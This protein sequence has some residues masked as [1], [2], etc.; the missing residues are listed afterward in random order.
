MIPFQAGS[1]V[2]ERIAAF[3]RSWGREG[4]FD[5]LA[6]LLFAYQYENN[7][8]YR[9]FCDSRGA[10]PGTII[11]PQIPAVPADAFR[12]ANLTCK[13]D[14]PAAIFL[15]SG[16]TG[17][18]GSVS[19]RGRHLMD[20][21][22]LK[23]YRRS[24]TQSFEQLAS[25]AAALPIRALMAASQDAPQSS[26]SFMVSALAKS[27][28]G[29]IFFWREGG[30]D[31]NAALSHLRG[32]HNP[33]LLFTTTFALV[34][35]LDH[36]GCCLALPTGSMVIE[37]GGFKGRSR[38]VE[39]EE[40]YLLA[41]ERLGIPLENIGSEYGMCEMASQFYDAHLQRRTEDGGRGKGEPSSHPPILPSTHPPTHP[42]SQRPNDPSPSVF[43]LPS[44]VP[45]G[46]K[47]GPPWVRTVFI[48]PATGELAAPGAPGILRHYDLANLNSVLAIQT[49]DVGLPVDNV[50]GFVLQGRLRSAPPRGCSLTIE[51]WRMSS[52][53]REP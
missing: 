10:L 32:D 6:L 48:D 14:P 37:T 2:F 1:D 12:T 38:T 34:E 45:R 13:D 43:R 46:I 22:A 33:V 8:P 51:E 30:P 42:T 41:S 39:R 52:A 4:T 35:L 29:S 23:L 15:T 5:E 21:H 9:R 24:L 40:L 31:L 53:Q 19:T 50:E 49:M 25:R 20:A 11:A 16:T 36:S 44:S 3:I 26:L 7:V 27:R 47:T 28:P 17:R 18:M